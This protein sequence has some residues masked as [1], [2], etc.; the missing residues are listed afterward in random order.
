MSRKISRNVKT[1]TVEAQPFASPFRQIKGITQL[2]EARLHRAG[3]STFAELG[4]LEPPAILSALEGV[5]G[6][7]LNQ[8]IEQKWV[9]EAQKLAAKKGKAMDQGELHGE[10]F[11]LNIFLNKQKLVHSTQ[12]LHVNS[13]EGDKWNGWDTDRLESFIISHSDVVLAGEN[14]EKS[15]VTIEEREQQRQVAPVIQPLE[16]IAEAVDAPQDTPEISFRTLEMS[17]ASGLPGKFLHQGEPFELRLST[18]DMNVKI[19]EADL[20]YTAA[21][22]AKSLDTSKRVSL[23][24][25]QGVF[26]K[27]QKVIVIKVPKQDLAP[28]MYRVEAAMT[29]GSKSQAVGNPIQARTFLQVF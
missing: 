18:D 4:E 19:F 22:F 7:T 21:V 20:D 2:I 5:K 1:K 26:T 29:I 11:I 8:I 27:A 10:G 28:G 3:I 24:A 15:I 9:R 25:I 17:T 12:I 6:I 23:G 14:E 16:S 13:D